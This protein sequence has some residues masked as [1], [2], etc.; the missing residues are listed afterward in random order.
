[1]GRLLARYAVAD[2]V[3]ADQCGE[4]LRAAVANA[5]LG[6]MEATLRTLYSSLP[7]QQLATVD[8]REALCAVALRALAI[9]AGIRS[10]PEESTALGRS[11]VTLEDGGNVFEFKM[12]GRGDPLEQAARKSCADRHRNFGDRAHVVG[13][14][15]DPSQRNIE[16]FDAVRPFRSAPA[17]NRPVGCRVRSVAVE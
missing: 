5:D 2:R 7:H 4:D 1:M 11:D 14:T 12:K 15:M 6:R 3:L 8:R 10:T 9:G 17:L 16:R 13:V